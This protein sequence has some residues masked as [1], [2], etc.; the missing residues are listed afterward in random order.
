MNNEAIKNDDAVENSPEN[1]FY[2]M[3]PFLENA[4]DAEG[5]QELC[6]LMGM[7]DSN[8]LITIELVSRSNVNKEPVKPSDVFRVSILKEVV[9]LVLV[10][11]HPELKEIPEDFT[12]SDQYNKMTGD[13]IQSGNILKIRVFEH[14]IITREQYFSYRCTG[15]MEK[16]AESIK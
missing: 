7:D 11:Y 14:L 15:L 5:Q 1:L 9:K 4:I 6:W 12:P 3:Q 8:R 2:L 16:L 10:N 13:M